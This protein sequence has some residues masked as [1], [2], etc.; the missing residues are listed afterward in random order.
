M[1]PLS[2]SR[3]T[4]VLTQVSFAGS[5]WRKS[6][7][8]TLYCFAIIKI[9]RNSNGDKSFDGLDFCFIFVLFCLLISLICHPLLDFLDSCHSKLDLES[10]N[11][12]KAYWGSR[13]PITNSIFLD[14]E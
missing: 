3:L 12:R 1:K 8:V 4:W 13:F 11:L 14:P 10:K 6:L 9:I 2:T 7:I 5:W